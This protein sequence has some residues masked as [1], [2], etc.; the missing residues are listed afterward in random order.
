[1]EKPIIQ[2][3]MDAPKHPDYLVFV[4]PDIAEIFK[5]KDS[6]YQSDI[7]MAQIIKELRKVNA[8]LYGKG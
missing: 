7:L 2:F 1:M 5:G 6:Y 4:D 8:V 3:Q